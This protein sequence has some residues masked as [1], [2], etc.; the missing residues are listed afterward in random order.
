MH[1]TKIARAKMI[2][3]DIHEHLRLEI[4]RGA[5]NAL[6][7]LLAPEK[8]TL[9]TC[10]WRNMHARVQCESRRTLD[11]RVA[12]AASQEV[13]CIDFVVVREEFWY[14]RFVLEQSEREQPV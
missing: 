4:I 7:A 9:R 12:T 13:E 2:V 11:L 5:L 1:Q 8:A 3:A 14:V 10:A 6:F